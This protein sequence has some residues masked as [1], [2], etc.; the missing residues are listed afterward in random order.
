MYKTAT[1]FKS[2]FV[3]VVA[4]SAL[5]AASAAF[6]GK[7]NPGKAKG[8]PGKDVDGANLVEIAMAINEDSG[9]FS[10]LLA[11][12]GCYTD[13]ETGANPFV[14]LLTGDEKYTLFAP[15]DAAFVSLLGRL[16]V[17]PEDVCTLAE[18]GTLATVLSYHVVE[19]RRFSNSV[20]NTNNIKMISTLAG[21]DFTT[22]VTMDGTPM[23]SDV[24]GQE[25]GV[26]A[27]FVNVNAVNGVI[28]VIDTVLLPI[29]LPDPE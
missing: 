20:F 25:I 9:E 15:T 14:G 12:V 6:A 29:D 2:A 28:H 22:Y 19:G 8:K 7:D 11:A 10:A 5:I 27:P 1:K 23:L 26:V 3:S 4:A 24:D 17:A 13:P 18:D 16:N 21:V